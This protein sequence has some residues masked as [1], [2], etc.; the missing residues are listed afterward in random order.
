MIKLRTLAGYASAVLLAASP[1][2]ADTLVAT[3]PG[4][5]CTSPDVLAKLTL[6][7]G[8]SRIGTAGEK[9]GDKA[10]RVSGG[11]IDIPPSAR[12]TVQTTRRRTT[13]VTFDAGD[14]PRTFVVPNIDFGPVADAGPTPAGAAAGA[15]GAHPPDAQCMA[16]GQR[17][18]QGGRGTKQALTGCHAS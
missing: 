10:L 3:R 7:D 11:C 6:P 13:I 5:M 4:L 15:P 18:A 12:V 17:M 8:S 2:A 1:A 16:L 14:G 9:P